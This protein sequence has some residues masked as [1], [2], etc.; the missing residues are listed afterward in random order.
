[1]LDRFGLGGSD[2]SKEEKAADAFEEHLS[3]YVL[4]KSNVIAVN[5]TSGD[6]QLASKAANTLAEAYLSWQRHAKLL[7]TKDATTWLSSQIEELRKKVAGSE[8]AVEKFR[9]ITAS[10][11]APTKPL[12]TPSSFRS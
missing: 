12:S 5:Y 11:R 2:K 9:S 7:Q 8:A 3:V 1:M 6:P 10:T 4:T